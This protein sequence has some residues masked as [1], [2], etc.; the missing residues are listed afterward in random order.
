MVIAGAK[1]GGMDGGQA[2]NIHM[3]WY[4]LILCMLKNKYDFIS[5]SNVKSH[6]S[7]ADEMNG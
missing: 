2:G 5:S 1:K 4:V 6:Q 7:N 3:T